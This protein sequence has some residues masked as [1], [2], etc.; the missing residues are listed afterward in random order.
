MFK[1]QSAM[2]RVEPLHEMRCKLQDMRRK[3]NSFWKKVLIEI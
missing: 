2:R 3:L 1:K